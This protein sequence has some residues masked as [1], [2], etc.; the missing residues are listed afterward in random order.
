L[1]VAKP[2]EEEEL[3]VAHRAQDAMT[4]PGIFF[5]WGELYTQAKTKSIEKTILI[6]KSTGQYQSPKPSGF[7][8]TSWCISTDW[9]ITC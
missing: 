3:L 7:I 8:F 9:V 1:A 6:L 5:S 4:E 2:R